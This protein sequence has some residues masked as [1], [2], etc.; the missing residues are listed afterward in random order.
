MFI[1]D[2][3]PFDNKYGI[4]RYYNDNNIR[5]D[6]ILNNSNPYLWNYRKLYNKAIPDW[7]DHILINSETKF[8]ENNYHKI[9]KL[10][11]EYINEMKEHPENL[12]SLSKGTWSRISIYDNI[13]WRND[14]LNQSILNEIK[15]NFRIAY[16]HGF[17][18]FLPIKKNSDSAPRLGHLHPLAVLRAHTGEFGTV[19]LE[20]AVHGLGAP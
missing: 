6:T 15:N 8:L 20:P 1:D 5:L 17:I 11:N 2:S 7:T 13:G 16:N 3:I 10:Y 19:L 18:F 12:T 14:K 9:N 4:T